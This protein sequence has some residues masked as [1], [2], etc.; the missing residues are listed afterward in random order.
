MTTNLKNILLRGLLL[1]A[2]LLAVVIAASAQVTSSIQGQI[3]DKSG[4]IVP[5]VE[6][7]ATN[8]ATG[9]MRKAISADDGFYRITDLLPGVYTVQ[10]GQTGFKTAVKAD[11]D[12]KA[13][14]VVGL[15]LT[16][17]AETV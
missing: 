11:I 6:V 7:S 2:F 13:Q 14:S 15:N 5:G 1:T 17:E 9:V 10:A 8:I 3:T 12:V 4:A 16:L